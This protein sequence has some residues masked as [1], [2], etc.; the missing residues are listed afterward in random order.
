MD[1]GPLGRVEEPE[2]IAAVFAFLAS[3]DAAVINGAD[4]HADG[5]KYLGKQ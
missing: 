3:D 1:L 2:E 4:I 5:G